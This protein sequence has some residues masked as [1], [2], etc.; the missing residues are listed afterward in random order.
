MSI[1]LSAAERRPL[2]LQAALREQRQRELVNEYLSKLAPSSEVSIDNTA[3]D[4][5]LQK[6]N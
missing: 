1:R 3:L 6:V 4:A 2:I 5:A